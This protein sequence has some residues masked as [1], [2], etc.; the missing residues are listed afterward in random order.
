M[1]RTTFAQH[2]VHRLMRER[3]AFAREFATAGRLRTCIIDDL[4]PAD[5]AKRIHDLFPPADRLIRQKTFR[6]FKYASSQMNLYHPLLEELVFAFQEPPLLDVVAD[7]TGI[8]PLL[9]DPTLYVSGLSLMTRGCFVNPHLDNSHDRERRRYRVLNLLFYVTPDW[10]DDY[11]G[12]LQLWEQGFT[13]PPRT[14]AYRFNRL[15]IM[16]TTR[17]SYHSVT[18]VSHT[19]GRC[20]VSNYLFSPRPIDGK[21]YFHVTSFR[22]TPPHVFADAILRTDTF[23]RNMLRKLFPLG[24]RDN[25]HVYHRQ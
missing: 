16:E 9:P 17:S 18:E 2:I 8:R 13:V 19:R 23:V 24:L 6:E 15:V 4:L 14:I 22:A 11:G 20:C 5:E 25:P 10:K 7:L 21:D 12:H 3:D 1:D